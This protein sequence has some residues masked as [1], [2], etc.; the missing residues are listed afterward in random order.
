MDWSNT[1]AD[2]YVSVR[3]TSESESRRA[4][5]TTELLAPPKRVTSIFASMRGCSR[6]IAVLFVRYLGI[7]VAFDICYRRHVMYVV[8][9]EDY[10]WGEREIKR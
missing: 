1:V 4:L 3:R 7:R 8:L 5:T 9:Y 10:C 2:S 6:E